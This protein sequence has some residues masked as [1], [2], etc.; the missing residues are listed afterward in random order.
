MRRPTSLHDCGRDSDDDDFR[1]MDYD[2]VALTNNL[3]QALRYGIYSN[4]DMEE[5]QG[6]LEHDDED[7]YFDD[8]SAEVVICSLR[9][10]DDQD[11]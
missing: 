10:G 3:S 6:T 9:L 2:V 11:G 1:D 7:V 5:N 4:D 8:E